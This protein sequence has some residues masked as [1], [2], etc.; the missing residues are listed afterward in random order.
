MRAIS[1]ELLDEWAGRPDEWAGESGE[2]QPLLGQAL[3]SG[4]FVLAGEAS[5]LVAEVKPAGDVVREISA[6]AAALLAS[7]RADTLFAGEEE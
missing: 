7:A 1:N 3:M 2:L 4:D 6:D 5:G